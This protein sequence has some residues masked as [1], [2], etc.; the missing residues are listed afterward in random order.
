MQD[1]SHLPQELHLS[2]S[3]LMPPLMRMACLGHPF[4]QIPHSVHIS[5]LIRAFTA[6]SNTSLAFFASGAVT[7]TW[8]PPKSF[9]LPF[10]I[11]SSAISNSGEYFTSPT[12]LRA[13]STYEKSLTLSILT[14]ASME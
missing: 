3:T 9:A 8:P 11:F 7:D 5:A 10:G 4:S 2:G 12:V 1:F 13:S 6:L 14:T